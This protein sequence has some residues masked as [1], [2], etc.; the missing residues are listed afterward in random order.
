MARMDARDVGLLYNEA[1]SIRSFRESDWRLAAAYC[2]PQHYGSWQTDGPAMY[3]PNGQ[4]SAR[5]TVFDSTG[6]RSLPKYM[7]VL[8]RLA[9]PA[10]TRYQTLTPS[11]KYLLKSP[12]V[13]Q[14]FDDLTDLHIK[15]RENPVAGFRSASNEVYASMGVYGT[16]PLFVGQ[17]PKNAIHRLN[18]FMYKAC[19]LRDVF[20]LVDANNEVVAVFRRMYMN[21]RQFKAMF[22]GK[23]LPK[24]MATEGNKASPSETTMFEFV[25]YVAVRDLSDFDEKAID[26][27][28]HPICAHY[29]C[30]TADPEYVGDESGYRSMPYLTPRTFTI[31]GDAYG[32]SPAQMA[33]S[34][35]GGASAIK[36]VYLKQGNK[37]ADPVLLSHDDGALN[38]EID[39]RPGAVNAG[40][41]DRQGRELVKPL[42]TGN[43][44]VIERLLEMDIEAIEDCF[45]VT[46][47]TILQERPEM[48]A[49]QVVEEASQVAAMLSPTMGRLQSELLAPTTSREIDLLDEMGL[50]P[51]MPPELIEAQGEYEINYT[52]P[53]AKGVYAEETAGF[54]RTVEMSIG[55]A[56]ATGDPSA[57]DWF[58]LDTAIPEIS[59]NN[60]VP[61]RWMRTLDKVQALR[62][63]R[64]DQQEQQSLMQNAGGLAQAGKAAA[65]IQEG[66][67]Q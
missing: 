14:Y 9:T 49:T 1:K 28:R 60:A 33:L 8:E 15:F 36:K 7:A 57:L 3:G 50:M 12:R 54:M 40:G 38:G 13:R 19:P 31:A 43:F 32:F 62:E 66:A 4:S 10:G 22:P 51:E 16:G 52:S 59:S 39:Q 55:I 2:L 44:Q 34:A 11:D 53:M 24:A 20:F 17:R 46:L 64:A 26:H 45:F 61:Q 63:D 5:R 37:A 27:R 21:V 6:T 67:A 47:F 58:D 65:E 29:V 56:T 30:M 48:T 41:L 35:L 18:A 23:D 42:Q 25:H